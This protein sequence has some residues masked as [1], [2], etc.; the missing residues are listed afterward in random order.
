MALVYLFAS[1]EADVVGIASTAGNVPVQQVC[2]N[3]LG[4]LELGQ[5]TGVPA[6]KGP[7]QPVRT[8]LRTAG[9]TPGPAGLGFP[10]L[11]AQE[12]QLPPHHAA[13]DGVGAPQARHR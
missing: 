8:P 9:D 1:D 11:P 6:F 3:N 2:R 7:E 12:L 13:E 4:L 10:P 5:I